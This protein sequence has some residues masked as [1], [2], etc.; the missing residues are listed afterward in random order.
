VLPSPPLQ[1]LGGEPP[2]TKITSF[3]E[4]TAIHCREVSPPPPLNVLPP[5]PPRILNTL[6]IQDWLTVGFCAALPIKLSLTYLFLIPSLVL[7]WAGIFCGKGNVHKDWLKVHSPLLFF[8]VY[9]SVT[10]FLGINPL[11]SLKSSLYLAFLSTTCFLIAAYIQRRGAIGLLGVFLGSQTVA[12]INTIV[13]SGSHG[14][15]PRIFL[16]EVT[17][18][19]QFSI[20]FVLALAWSVAASNHLDLGASETRFRRNYALFILALSLAFFSFFSLTLALFGIFLGYELIKISRYSCI[21]KRLKEICYLSTPLIAAGLVADLKRGPWLGAFIGATLIIVMCKR[22]L[23]PILLLC[24]A[25]AALMLQPVAER[26]NSV[27]EHFYI[28]G[29]RNAIWQIGWELMSQFPLGIGLKNSPILQAFSHLIPPELTHFHNNLINLT[30]ETGLIGTTL[31]F[32]WIWEICR[33]TL[34][35]GSFWLWIVAPLIAWQVAGLVEYNIGDKE[36]ILSIYFIVGIGMGLPLS[37][38]GLENPQIDNG[39][40]LR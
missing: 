11:K 12:A 5:F 24:I 4:R 7:F 14:Y 37:D 2:L 39:Q 1:S 9:A 40:K 34:K 10:S 38:A 26:I 25:S 27:S 6:A 35:K 8:V 18:A 17:Q 20:A 16:G 32:W 31:Y 19:G 29:G 22:Q 3:S 28:A 15:I 30:V 21:L 33:M 36:V 23:V 13:S